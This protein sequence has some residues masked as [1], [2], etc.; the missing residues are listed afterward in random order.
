[1]LPDDEVFA[2]AFFLDARPDSENHGS[3]TPTFRRGDEAATGRP[4]RAAI[5]RLFDCHGLG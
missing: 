3:Y 4:A 5:L 1:M 2:L